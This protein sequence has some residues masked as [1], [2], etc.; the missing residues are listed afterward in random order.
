M[1]E[2]ERDEKQCI[3]CTFV[4]WKKTP[5]DDDHHFVVHLRE[6]IKNRATFAEKKNELLVS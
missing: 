2:R 3:C 5:F 6:T 4:N 1:L